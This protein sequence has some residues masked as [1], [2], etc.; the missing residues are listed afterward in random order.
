M[1]SAEVWCE[2]GSLRKSIGVW[3]LAGNRANE[4]E[5][6]HNLEPAGRWDFRVRCTGRKNRHGWKS[7]HQ[8]NEEEILFVGRSHEP[9][10]GQGEMK[11]KKLFIVRDGNWQCALEW[12]RG[13]CAICVKSLDNRRQKL[14]LQTSDRSKVMPFL[15]NVNS[16]NSV[17][18][19]E[20]EPCQCGEIKRSHPREWRSVLRLWVHEGESL[21]TYERSVSW[22]PNSDTSFQM[23]AIIIAILLHKNHSIVKVQ[24]LPRACHPKYGLS[25]TSRVGFYAQ[26]WLFSSWHET[27]KFVMYGPRTR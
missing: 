2:L 24:T 26:T 8:T 4:D 9:S 14:T 21:S 10:W 16:K 15:K 27:R 12:E 11:N 1:L 6:V 13:W 5:P 22:S 3:E 25:G 20:A 18:I 17:V 19:E 23:L 7:G